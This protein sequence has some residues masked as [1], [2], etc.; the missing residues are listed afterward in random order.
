MWHNLINIEIWQISDP[1]PMCMS[2][3]SILGACQRGAHGVNFIKSLYYCIA[4]PI[5]DI[6]NESFKSNV[7][8]SFEKI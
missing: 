7:S 6:F 2:L 1:C 3:V 5:A 4:K 8:L